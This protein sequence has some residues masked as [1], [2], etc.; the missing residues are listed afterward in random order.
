MNDSATCPIWGTPA[1]EVRP[2]GINGR[3]IESPRAGGRYF[4]SGTAET[5]VKKRDASLL[6][7]PVNA[8]DRY[9]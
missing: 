7:Y 9:M 1:S 5:T 4:I 3:W 8:H 6:A 2:S